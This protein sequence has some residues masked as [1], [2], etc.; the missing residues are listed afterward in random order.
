M[1]ESHRIDVEIDV[2]EDDEVI[3]V[4]GT[5]VGELQIVGSVSIVARV[6]RIERAHI[7]GLHP[8]ALGRAGLNAIGRKFLEEADVDKIIVQGGTRTTG[9]NKGRRPRAFVFPH[10]EAGS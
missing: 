9:R 5:P 10:G 7:Q 2:V 3:V 4:I 6:L 1:W 8:G